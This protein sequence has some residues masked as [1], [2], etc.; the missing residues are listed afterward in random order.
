MLRCLLFSSLHGALLAL[1]P[2]GRPCPALDRH[3]ELARLDDSGFGVRVRRWG[4][5]GQHRKYECVTWGNCG[6]G[7]CCLREMLLGQA[8]PRL[9]NRAFRLLGS[10]LVSV[11]QKCHHFDLNA[12][13]QL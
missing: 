3:G 4:V 7:K 2:H 9:G 12:R 8:G 10:F 6:S 1:E 5:G 13:V 11:L